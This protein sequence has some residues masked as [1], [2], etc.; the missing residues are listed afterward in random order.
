MVL[1]F[2]ATSTEIT[3]E[4]LSGNLNTHNT[5]F[6]YHVLLIHY[7]VHVENEEFCFNNI[8]LLEASCLAYSLVTVFTFLDSQTLSAA[9]HHV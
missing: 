6:I 8:D 3:D 4:R 1:I 2:A 9:Y 7:C 5:L